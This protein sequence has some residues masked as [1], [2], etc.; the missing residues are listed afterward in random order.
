[1]ISRGI[2]DLLDIQRQE[3]LLLWILEQTQGDNGD[4][5]NWL[6]WYFNTILTTVDDSKMPND[7]MMAKLIL[8]ILSIN[9]SLIC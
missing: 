7:L 6:K 3:T 8:G 1:M 9:I 4:T 5:I 2:C